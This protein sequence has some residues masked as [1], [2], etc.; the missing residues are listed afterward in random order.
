MLDGDC[1]NSGSRG[2]RANKLRTLDEARLRLYPVWA[3]ASVGK[4]SCR[5]KSLRSS[6]FCGGMGSEMEGCPTEPSLISSSFSDDFFLLR[7]PIKRMAAIVP[8]TPS[9]MPEKTPAA[10]APAGYCGQCS[11]VVV[12]F[13]TGRA[14]FVGDAVDDVEEEVLLAVLDALDVD[15][16]EDEDDDVCKTQLP[17]RHE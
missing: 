7:R 9:K 17:S 1:G 5:R 14:D 11:A 4:G 16:D 10:T 2:D 15:E 6:P 8:K 3:F 13:E 12:E